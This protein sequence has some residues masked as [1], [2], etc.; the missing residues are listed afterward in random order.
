MSIRETSN[1]TVAHD[2]LERRF[3]T[4]MFCDMVGSTALSEKLDPEDLR[5]ILDIFRTTACRIVE[6][7]QGHVASIQGDGL[8]VYF[9]Y[10]ATHEDDAV[11]AVRAG[12]EILEALEQASL[13]ARALHDV[14]IQARIGIHTGLVVIDN[15]VAESQALENTAVGA[16]PNI[17]ARI[18]SL[19]EP[20][21]M[22]VS[23]VTWRL[24]KFEFNTI[25]LGRKELRGVKKPV[26]VFRVESSVDDEHALPLGS[27]SGVT[28]RVNREREIERLR[29]M[30][31]TSRSGHGCSVLVVGEAG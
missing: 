8:L 14:D 7:F 28:D 24:L 16:T 3:F 29:E 1:V 19:A 4:V 17:A 9:G 26:Q 23:S 13:R 22:L 11:R 21:E 18:Q 31:Q 6:R 12:L 5:E 30:W 20:N 2:S 25:S 27:L 10:P 15:V